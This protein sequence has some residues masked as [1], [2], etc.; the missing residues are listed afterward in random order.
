MAGSVGVAARLRGWVQQH[1]DVAAIAVIA[2]A[3]L[4]VRAQ[5]V[6]R[7][8]V[9]MA[10]DSKGYFLP[11][12]DLA[13]G[14]GFGIGFRRTPVYPLF[15]AGSLKLFGEDL[16]AIVL[17]Q[18]LL[19]VGTAVLTYLLGKLTVG[20]LAGLLAGLLVA[21]NGA[22]V[23]GEH[24]LM[25]EGLFIP[26][27]ALALLA[28]LKSTAFRMQLPSPQPSPRGGGLSPPPLGEGWVRAVPPLLFAGLLVGLA[29][30]TRPVAQPL[31]LLAPL[32]L[33]LAGHRS[34][35]TLVGSAIYGLGFAAVLVPWALYNAAAHGEASTSGVMGQAMLARTAYYDRGFVFFDANLP[36][37]GPDAPRAA[38]RR[39]VQ[40]AMRERLQGGAISRRLQAELSLSDTE[41]AR[42][43]R[44]LALDAIRRQPDHYLRGT[45]AMT[46]QLYQGEYDR[47]GY[48]W[49][50]QG[51]RLSRDEWPERVEHLLANPTEAQ[52]QERP[53]AE[54]ATDFWQP[55]YW[56]PWLP[57]LSFVGPALAFL[58]GGPARGLVVL[59]AA[60]FVLLLVSAAIN[61]PL[62]RY[63]YPVDPYIALGAASAVV[64]GARLA[65][66]RLRPPCT[67]PAQ[68]E[69]EPARI[70]PSGMAPS[71]PG[72]G[73]S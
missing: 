13:T 72:G 40:N 50:T 4:L 58:A 55:S 54:A 29:A 11:A 47:L 59:G 44:D 39:I 35:S 3:A 49:K 37:R 46:W 51:R 31:V 2:T 33:L 28:L 38:A 22:L 5:V 71:S 66:G 14:Q 45:T 17:L 53:R 21:V 36:D 68:H 23:I 12:Y 16:Q 69:E 18:H 8:P 9:F 42:L 70:A 32:A 34:R 56:S 27:L 48:D 63:R 25:A 30:L 65:L 41:L 20:R 6:F 24:Y 26:L 57:L 61:G 1:P 60:T 64:L 19:G 43:N 7:A 15:L 62:P 73:V 52:N 67:A 10:P